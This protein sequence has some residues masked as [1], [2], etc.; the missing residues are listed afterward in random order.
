MGAKISYE[1]IFDTATLYGTG[2]AGYYYVSYALEAQA[3]ALHTQ[4]LKDA[5]RYDRTSLIIQMEL[6]DHSNPDA[7][8]MDLMGL[9]SMKMYNVAGD[10]IHGSVTGE[11]QISEWNDPDN[12]GAGTTTSYLP[13]TA[14]VPPNDQ[15][16]PHTFVELVRQY[17]VVAI[18]V[19]VDYTAVTDFSY[20]D[21]GRLWLG[22][23]WELPD[24][25]DA[26]WEQTIQDDGSIIRSRGQQGFAETRQRYR[27]LDVNMG[28]IKEVDA[29]GDANDLT[30]PNLQD[31]Y[32]QVGTTG[33][34]IILPRTN[35]DHMIHKVGMYGH[36]DKSTPIKHQAGEY[37]RSGFRVRELV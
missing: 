22:S 31:M 14:W 28:K 30:Y 24:G 8:A 5:F 17:D 11:L 32:W 15:L 6:A 23:L 3:K 20:V 16:E 34:M 9:L 18:A 29:F 21:I 37:Y 27:V 1:N 13:F 19:L 2:G 10:R 33:D 4:Q 12:T 7:L 36:I 26:K 35:S 25:I